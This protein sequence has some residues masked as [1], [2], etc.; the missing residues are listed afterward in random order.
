MKTTVETNVETSV[1]N[2]VETHVDDLTRPGQRPGEFK[3][4]QRLLSAM[5]G[6]PSAKLAKAEQNP[7]HINRVAKYNIPYTIGIPI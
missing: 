1:E 7:L 3:G 6:S 5:L 2:H 4:W